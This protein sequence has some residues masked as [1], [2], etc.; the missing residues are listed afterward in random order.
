MNIKEFITECQ[1]WDVFKKLSIYIV[2]SWLL[3]QVLGSTWESL[4]LP[5][6]VNTYL[7]V[8]LLVGFP[9]YIYYV[10]KY[11]I[12]PFIKKSV[13]DP[14]ALDIDN[15]YKKKF[16]RIYL[17]ALSV[18]AVLA[19]L[20]VVSITKNKL[21]SAVNELP[22][23]VESDK[24]AVL[25]FD[26]NTGDQELDIIGKM[27]VDWLIHGITQYEAGQVISPK[28][29]EDY[30]SVLKSS[31][32]GGQDNLIKQVFKPSKIISGNYYLKDGNLL[33]QCSILDGS[34]NKTLITFNNVLCSKENSLECIEDIKQS[35]LTY[36][37]QGDSLKA[38][39]L[40]ETPPKYQAYLYKLEAE[41]KY[42]NIPKH[43]YENLLKAIQEDPNFFEP[44][45]MLISHFY[46]EGQFTKADS[47]LKSLSSKT[48]AN[49]RQLNILSAYDALLKGN[50][51]NVFRYWKNEYNYAPFHLQTNSTVMV[52]AQQYINQPS[53]SDSLFAEIKMNDLDVTNC[54]N[55]EFRYYIQA[56]SLIERD[57]QKEAIALLEPLISKNKGVSYLK[58]ALLVA[59]TREGLIDKVNDLMETIEIY[60]EHDILL[61]GN[62]NIGRELLLQNNIELA[63]TFFKKVIAEHG[64]HSE[65][66]KLA[67]ANYYLKNFEGALMYFE[68]L[69]Q[70][71]VTLNPYDLGLM[72]NCFAQINNEEEV[73]IVLELLL[74]KKNNFDFGATDYALARFYAIK[75]DKK[76]VFYHLRK[77]VAA[78]HQFEPDT[79]QNDPHFLAYRDTDE[80]KNIL[81]FWH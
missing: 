11:Q 50:N 45:V 14:D 51:R 38:L 58:K 66:K 71:K 78:G 34:M 31:L 4:G 2:T 1:K 7:L 39:N 74:S 22:K 6:V 9:F 19:F 21:N 61:E 43:Y 26:N 80:F 68:N 59:Y 27:A 57:K 44:K 62:L 53:A 24:I 56:F 36:L 40:Q 30:T 13:D 63:N 65:N 28:V 69:R 49:Q 67:R 15:T 17:G 77:A 23:F 29:V 33:M 54:A 3:I 72:A 25:K 70:E 47:L 8:M 5:K 32:N 37:I 64:G 76:Q 18:V 35:A 42:A 60:D 20:G 52:V 10:W 16:Q 81:T 41:E 48:G 75:E 55:C 73:N 46:N 12:A 79:F